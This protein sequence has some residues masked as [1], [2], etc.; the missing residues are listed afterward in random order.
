MVI[1]G[2]I[3]KEKKM[4]DEKEQ[5]EKL[6]EAWGSM[7]RFAFYTG[8]QRGVLSSMNSLCLRFSGMTFE[9]YTK[10]AFKPQLNQMFTCRQAM[11]LLGGLLASINELIKV[12]EQEA[13]KE[14]E[15]ENENETKSSGL[16]TEGN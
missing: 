6:V 4:N 3:N 15:K 8:V 12:A 9:A 5:L 1:N 11:Q 13:K 16:V 2:H 10:A 7:N 14:M